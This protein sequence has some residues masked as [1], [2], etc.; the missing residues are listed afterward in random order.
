MNYKFHF[1]GL[2]DYNN[3]AD[4]AVADVIIKNNIKDAAAN[5]L[6]SHI[7]NAEI[8]LLAR[9]KNSELFD[10]FEVRRPEE[11][12]KLLNSVYYEWKE[13]IEN[14]PEDDFDKI[15]EYTNIKGERVKAKIREIFIHMI[16][17][18]TYHRGQVASV[19]RK[20]NIEPP[21]TDFI[22]YSR[23]KN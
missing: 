9:I 17:H 19:V 11:N 10:P 22:T 4:K 18:S 20:L 21:V 14:L 3:W 16:N 2:L 23:L 1:L 6:F 12:V 7:I 5:S 15:I 8:I 13:F